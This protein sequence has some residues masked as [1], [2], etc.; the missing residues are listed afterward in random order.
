[1]PKA[2]INIEK[3]LEAHVITYKDRYYRL[4]YSYVRNSEDALDIVQDSII[5]AL[6]SI[7]SL[8]EPSFIATWFYRIIVNTSLDF[9]RKNK[10]LVLLDEEILCSIETGEADKYPDIDLQAA[11][12]ALPHDCRSIIILRYF[13]DLKLEEIAEVLDENINTIKT[14]LYKSLKRLRIKI[15]EV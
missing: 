12:E 7:E 13:E 10:K 14:R 6:L 11:L 4:A 1:M 5:K 3:Q 9:L 8:K 15:E 2:K